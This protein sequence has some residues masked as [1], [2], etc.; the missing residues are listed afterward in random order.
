MYIHLTLHLHKKYI[1]KDIK[2]NPAKAGE[3]EKMGEGGN[4][5]HYF[6]VA[7][8]NTIFLYMS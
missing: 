4:K 8:K 1:S 5:R 3:Y 6:K 7:V 2:K